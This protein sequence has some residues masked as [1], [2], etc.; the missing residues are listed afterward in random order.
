MQQNEI[1]KFRKERELDRLD[2]MKKEKELK[3]NLEEMERCEKLLEKLHAHF[4][5]AEKELAILKSRKA[6]REK[7]EKEVN[8][9]AVV[10][11]C[12]ASPPPHNRQYMS[13]LCFFFELCL[14]FFFFNENVNFMLLV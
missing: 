6:Y 7:R 13:V 4:L 2:R 10:I 12:E 1:E 5:A 9:E 3:E 8:I 11:D 14:L